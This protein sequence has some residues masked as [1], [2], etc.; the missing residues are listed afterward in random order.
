MSHVLEPSAEVSA[1]L[2]FGSSSWCSALEVSQAPH[3]EKGDQEKD[4]KLDLIFVNNR[5][6]HK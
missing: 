5:S 6:L 4:P 2:C 3:L 1:E